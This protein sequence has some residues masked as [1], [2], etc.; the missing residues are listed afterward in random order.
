MRRPETIWLVGS[1]KSTWQAI[2]LT[3]TS[4]NWWED[5]LIHR[6]CWGSALGWASLI[7]QESFVAGLNLFNIPVWLF[8]SPSQYGITLSLFS[9]WKLWKRHAICNTLTCY[10]CCQFPQDQTLPC[11]HSHSLFVFV[12]RSSL[13]DLVSLPYHIDCA[14]VD[15][16][17]LTN[18]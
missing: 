2:F 13:L 3:D 1:W 6:L 7:Y 12:I 15:L 18:Q 4:Q 17:S 8:T 16:L 10:W 11:Q 9:F 14:A 5:N